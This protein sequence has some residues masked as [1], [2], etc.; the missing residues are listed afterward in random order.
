MSACHRVV[1]VPS[2]LQHW[3]L[4]PP[5]RTRCSLTACPTRSTWQSSKRRLPVPRIFTPLCWTVPTRSQARLLH[6]LPALEVPCELA[7]LGVGQAVWEGD[8]ERMKSG[9]KAVLSVSYSAVSTGAT[10]SRGQQRPAGSEQG[11]VFCRLPALFSNKGGLSTVPVDDLLEGC[12]TTWPVCEIPNWASLPPSV[13]D[14]D[15]V[16]AWGFCSFY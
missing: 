4:Q 2:T 1:T 14:S 9:L 8:R 12:S 5:S 10:A 3:C 6:H 7:G 15:L 13:L 11:G 16:W